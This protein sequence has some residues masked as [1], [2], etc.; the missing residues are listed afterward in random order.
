[1]SSSLRHAQ[2]DRMVTRLLVAGESRPFALAVTSSVSGEGVST[3]C[4]GL[5]CALARNTGK[6]IV[7]L[8]ANLRSSVQHELFGVPRTPG[9]HDY[10][11]GDEERRGHVSTAT[12]RLSALDLTVS[13]TAVHNLWLVPSGLAVSHPGQVLT[14]EAA[15]MAIRRLQRDFDYVLMDCPPVLAAAEAASFCRLADGIVIVVRAG[16]TPRDDVKRVQSIL[17][18]APVIGVILNGV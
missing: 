5:A 4:A 13:R 11:A 14:S 15:M 12:D 2:Y 17:E 7:L 6:R 3:V 10:V 16:L 1:M 8:D 9:L 18:G